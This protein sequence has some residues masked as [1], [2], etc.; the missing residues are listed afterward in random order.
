MNVIPAVKMRKLRQYFDEVTKEAGGFEGK[1]LSDKSVAAA[2]KMA[3]DGIRE[4]LAKFYP[5]IA[6][7]NKEFSFWKDLSQVVDDTIVRKT[8][9][10]PGLGATVMKGAAAAGG[11]ASG[12]VGGAVV[13]AQ[14]MGTLQR[15]MNS[16]AWRT[17][18]AVQKDRL[19]NAIA[20]GN[21]GEAERLIRMISATVTSATARNRTNQ[22]PEEQE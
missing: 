9:H 22:Q 1:N 14:T 11:M 13:G 4:E 5:D 10:G 18:S 7:I 21:R 16:T 3:A 20:K 6:K 12:G 8:G 19:A 17:V 15:A 2:H